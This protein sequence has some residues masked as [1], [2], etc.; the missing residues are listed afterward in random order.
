M[1]SMFGFRRRE[2]IRIWVHCVH[3]LSGYGKD[4]LRPESTGVCV[5]PQG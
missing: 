2:W 3:P 1:S 4:G 5:W